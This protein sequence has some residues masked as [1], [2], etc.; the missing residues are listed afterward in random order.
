MHIHHGCIKKE[1]SE[2]SFT[3]SSFFFALILLYK[4]IKGF[5]EFDKY[6][7]N[8]IWINIIII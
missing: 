2:R 7:T 1:K 8:D 6:K 3:N 4:R 5:M